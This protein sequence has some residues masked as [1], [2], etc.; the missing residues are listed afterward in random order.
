[1]QI[2]RV[3]TIKYTQKLKMGVQIKYGSKNLNRLKK[4]NISFF[5]S[6]YYNI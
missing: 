4:I 6:M 2:C 5:E 3:K 1:M